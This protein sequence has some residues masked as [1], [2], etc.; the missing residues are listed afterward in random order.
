MKHEDSFEERL[1]RQ[2]FRSPP[3][4]WRAEILAAARA[5][6]ANLESHEPS[7]SL[8][9]LLRGCL[10]PAPVA[11]AG[12]AAVWL[13]ILGLTLSSHDSDRTAAARLES[14]PPTVM[15]EAMKQ[16]QLLLAE[17]AGR[18]ESPA[19]QKPKTVAPR[20]RSER[21]EENLNA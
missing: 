3:E 13:V 20:P 4:S 21:R 10:G 5:G 19:A 18:P 7:G 8:L 9:N 6:A 14:P 17:L 2:P 15:R 1:Q 11:W 12:L 16:K